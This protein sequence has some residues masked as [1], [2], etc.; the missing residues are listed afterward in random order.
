VS[1]Q[2]RPDAPTCTCSDPPISVDC[3]SDHSHACAVSRWALRSGEATRVPDIEEYEVEDRIIN[4]VGR[5]VGGE[6][7]ASYDEIQALR[8]FIRSELRRERAKASGAGDGY[9]GLIEH[10]ATHP[11]AGP[12]PEEAGTTSTHRPCA[13]DPCAGFYIC[14]IH[15]PRA[16]GRPS[17]DHR[18]TG[19]GGGD[20]GPGPRFVMDHGVIHDLRTGKHVRTSDNGEEDGVNECFALLNSL[21]AEADDNLALLARGVELFSA[22]PKV[23]DSSRAT[24]DEDAFLHAYNLGY[25]DGADLDDGW[26]G[27]ERWS[28]EFTSATQETKR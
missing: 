21:A 4:K 19:A 24:S 17:F 9:Q 2:R 14:D 26:K 6:R 23:A 18:A 22:E 15:R 13:A 20:D 7:V 11:T 1:E 10:P 25:V 27:T 8:L 5:L 28:A 3:I 16:A 12:G